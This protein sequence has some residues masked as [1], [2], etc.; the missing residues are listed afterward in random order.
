LFVLAFV[1]ACSD[2]VPRPNLDRRRAVPPG[3]RPASR[4]V[5]SA[6]GFRWT[7]DWLIHYELWLITGRWDGGGRPHDTGT[8]ATDRGAHA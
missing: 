4:T 8:A 3:G 5:R 7:A 1:P 6:D 2:A